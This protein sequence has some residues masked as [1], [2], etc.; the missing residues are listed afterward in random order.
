MTLRLRTILVAAL[1]LLPQAAATAQTPAPAAPPAGDFPVFRELERQATDPAQPKHN[2]LSGISGL[3]Q[4]AHPSVVPTLVRLLD[5]PDVELRTAAAKALGWKGNRPA[6]APLG[7]RAT[8]ARE[9]PGVRTAAVASLGRIGDP[10]VVPLIEGLAKDPDPA[11]RREAMLFLIQAP[12]EM[13]TD[14]VTYGLILLEDLEQDGYTRGLAAVNLGETGDRRA[15]EAL[16]RVLQDPR[17]PKGYAELPTG[18]GGTRQA[19]VFASRLRSLHNVRAHAA[20]VLGQL[21]DQRAVPALLGALT[22]PDGMVR[23]ESASAIG[24]LKPPGAVAPLTQALHDR[25]A[26]VR[27]SAAVAIGLQGDPAAVAPLRE[28]LGDDSSSVRVEAALALGLLGD[29]GA[30]EALQTMARN[31]PVP[32]A[33]RA[34]LASLARLGPPKPGQ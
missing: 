6:L 2:R 19:Q 10:A 15:V 23:M 12:P 9:D 25:E 18:E 11:V 3:A 34:A 24:R 8:D 33:R 20:L 30:R 28:A 26:R 21:G 27:Q 7:A 16:I 22:D 32:A 5:D 13:R 1:L 17:L 4:A 31:D 14:R 29:E